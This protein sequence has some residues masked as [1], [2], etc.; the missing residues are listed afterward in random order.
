MKNIFLAAITVIFLTTTGLA[1]TKKAEAILSEV[2]EKTQ[3]YRSMKINFT[4]EMENQKADIHESE[5]GMLLVKGD[6]Y[7]LEIAGQVVINDGETLWTYIEEADEVQINSIEEDDE[8]IISP[9]KLLTS[10]D[11]KFKPKYVKDDVWSGHKVHILELKPK[12]DKTYSSVELKVDINKKRVLQIR[13][14]DKTDNVFSYSVT[15]FKPNVLFEYSDFTF[16]PDDYPGIEV[17]DMR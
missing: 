14:F 13:I 6:K 16:N 7:R 1:Q 2:A 11:E 3:S 9:T 15:E 12:E 4:Y 17:I 8:D 10:Y 5:K